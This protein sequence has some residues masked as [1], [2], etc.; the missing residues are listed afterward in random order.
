M[1]TLVHAGF[2]NTTN[3]M[4]NVFVFFQRYSFRAMDAQYVEPPYVGTKRLEKIDE[5]EEIRKY[6]SFRIRSKA[7]VKRQLHLKTILVLY[8]D[9]LEFIQFSRNHDLRGGDFPEIMYSGVPNKLDT[10]IALFKEIL[11]RGEG[12]V[13]N[14]N[15]PAEAVKQRAIQHLDEMLRLY[16]NLPDEH[17]DKHSTMVV[18]GFQSPLFG[19]QVNEILR[20]AKE[21]P[22]SPSLYHNWVTQG[23]DSVLLLHFPYVSNGLELNVCDM[24]VAP[25]SLSPEE[26]EKTTVELSYSA[27]HNLQHFPH[28]SWICRLTDRGPQSRILFFFIVTNNLTLPSWMPNLDQN[29]QQDMARYNLECG[30]FVLERSNGTLFSDVLM[31]HVKESLKPGNTTTLTSAKCQFK[32]DNLEDRQELAIRENLQCRRDETLCMKVYNTVD[33]NEIRLQNAKNCL[34]HGHLKGLVGTYDLLESPIL[35]NSFF[36]RWALYDYLFND[37]AR[38]VPVGMLGVYD[39]NTTRKYFI[40]EIVEYPGNHP[41]INCKSARVTLDVLV[42]IFTRWSIAFDLYD[43]RINT[44]RPM[45]DNDTMVTLDQAACEER[46]VEDSAQKYRNDCSPYDTLSFLIQSMHSHSPVWWRCPRGHSFYYSPKNVMMK[47]TAC[48]VCTKYHDI[49]EIYDFLKLQPDVSCL[50]VEFP[51]IVKIAPTSDPQQQLDL[52]DD[53]EDEDV[54]DGGTEDAEDEKEGEEDEREEDEEDEIDANPEPPGEEGGE[55]IMMDANRAPMKYDVFFLYQKKYVC[56]VEF[57]DA[58]HN[59]EAQNQEDFI[60]V[61]HPPADAKKNVI[62]SAMGIHLLRIW[63]GRS[64]QHRPNAKARLGL[65]LRRFLTMVEQN[66]VTFSGTMTSFNRRV[67]RFHY[68]PPRIPIANR[69]W[70]PRYLLTRLQANMRPSELRLTA[71]ENLNLRKIPISII[72]DTQ[73]PEI[74]FTLQENV[75]LKN[76]EKAGRRHPCLKYV[77]R[78]HTQ[79]DRPTNRGYF[80]FIEEWKNR[81]SNQNMDFCVGHEVPRG[82]LMPT[83]YGLLVVASTENAN[84]SQVNVRGYRLE[85]QEVRPW[86]MPT[87]TLDVPSGLEQIE[88]I[89]KQFVRIKP[90]GT[91]PLNVPRCAYP[92]IASAST[93]KFSKAQLPPVVEPRDNRRDGPEQWPQGAHWA[94]PGNHIK[95]MHPDRIDPG[96]QGRSGRGGWREAPSSSDYEVEEV[97]RSGLTFSDMNEMYWILVKRGAT[98]YWISEPNFEYVFQPDAVVDRRPLS[99]FMVP[100]ERSRLRSGR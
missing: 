3:G 21:N 50:T 86:K 18:Q 23:K 48:Q 87:L 17:V 15:F 39:M 31:E 16:P 7:P 40:K 53:N 28:E 63:V 4:K 94:L 71:E 43:S 96:Y 81:A 44:T 41:W 60:G 79:V 72:F 80:T 100:F 88:S 68:P 49:R 89:A 77:I 98:K 58:S 13:D 57:D 52:D 36:M 56:A 51:L 84:Q 54:E 66:D 38:Q 91:R 14:M 95:F 45:V 90:P 85:S 32:R 76:M 75:L 10:L 35:K 24:V 99:V 37:L 69:G 19:S 5:F 73:V 97:T 65:I 64:S 34:K 12:Y 92:T 47:S 46:I 30:V 6:H 27:S 70:T 33:E 62:S 67:E 55:S 29:T 59:N 20:Q 83:K 93:W 42:D 25:V 2:E 74:P 8:S 26:R 11:G 1:Q 61:N 22:Y 78:V 9:G 82:R